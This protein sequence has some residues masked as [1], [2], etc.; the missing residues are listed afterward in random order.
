M[1]F[2]DGLGQVT[3]AEELDVSV[4]LLPEGDDGTDALEGMM[5]ELEAVEARVES[6]WT[7]AHKA[8][9]PE[10]PQPEVA[11]APPPAPPEKGTERRSK[12]GGGNYA[13]DERPSTPPG[14]RAPDELASATPARPGAT[15]P[16]TIRPDAAGSADGGSP[17]STGGGRGGRGAKQK[18]SKE[19]VELQTLKSKARSEVLHKAILRQVC[20]PKPLIVRTEAALDSEHLGALAVGSLVRVIETQRTPD[21]R[22]LRAKVI[23]PT[24]DEEEMLSALGSARGSAVGGSVIGSPRYGSPR[25]TNSKHPGEPLADPWHI[26]EERAE[27]YQRGETLSTSPERPAIAFRPKGFHA[28][29]EAVRAVQL[30]NGGGVVGGGAVSSGAGGSADVNGDGDGG[31]ASVPALFSQLLGW[32]RGANGGGA[33]GGGGSGGGGGGGG[34]CARALRRLVG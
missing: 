23:L 24:V 18:G 32:S 19:E 14:K 28:A 33:N 13:G 17:S 27:A 26:W 30:A 31:A 11:M 9:E 34:H 22:D 15:S 5:R 29:R 10:S 25:P 7:A 8:A 1:T 12:K 3:H 6:E 4:E 21:G 16:D 2:N 20:G